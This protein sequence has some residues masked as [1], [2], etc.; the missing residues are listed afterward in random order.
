MQIAYH[1]A[2]S[3]TLGPLIFAFT[4]KGLCALDLS[5]A[6]DPTILNQRFPNVTLQTDLFSP[7]QHEY[8]TQILTY[9]SD[10]TRTRP[11]IPLDFTPSHPSPFRLAVWSTLLTLPAGQTTSY[12]AL[13]TRLSYQPT[14]ARA[15][16]TAVGAN[17]IAVVVPCHRVLGGRGE[18]SGYRWGVEVKRRLLEME[19]VHVSGMGRMEVGEAI[20]SGSTG[21]FEKYR[22]TGTV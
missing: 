9:L 17:P 10:P 20:K 4:E 21:L 8:V 11:D 14:H 1:Q 18:L 22:C 16:A 2:T 12:S 15:V 19:G 3:P 6:A 7:A 13:A 5:P